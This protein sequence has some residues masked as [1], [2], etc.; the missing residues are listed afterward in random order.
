MKTDVISVVKP[1][2]ETA[3]NGE[4]IGADYYM[5]RLSAIR[6]RCGLDA[7]EVGLMAILKVCQKNSFEK[8]LPPEFRKISIILSFCFMC[9][10][11]NM[12]AYI[13]MLVHT[14]TEINSC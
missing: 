12:H 11:G 10:W 2:S 4:M 13:S 1:L 5:Q 6:A 9:E 14:H 7:I 8:Q 3:S